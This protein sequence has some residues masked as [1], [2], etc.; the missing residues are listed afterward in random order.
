M[1]GNFYDEYCQDLLS[2]FSG[3]VKHKTKNFGNARM[4]RNYFEEILI[5]QANRLAQKEEITDSM[6]ER[7]VVDDIPQKIY[8]DKL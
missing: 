4:V 3:E 8:I 5:N 7:I 6:L 1:A 2:Y